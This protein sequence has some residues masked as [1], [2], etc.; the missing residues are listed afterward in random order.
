MLEEDLQMEDFPAYYNLDDSD[1]ED[2]EQGTCSTPK[3]QCG[4]K[5]KNP[6]N[7]AANPSPTKKLRGM[8]GRLK[9]ILEM[10][11]DILV[12]I[13]GH[14]DPLALI[15]LTWTTKGF[16]ILLLSKNADSRAIWKASI[17][18]VPG[19]PPCPGDLSEPKY[20]YLAFVN[21][22][23]R[24]HKWGRNSNSIRIFWY[25][26]VRLCHSPCAEEEFSIRFPPNEWAD[27]PTLEPLIPIAEFAARRYFSKRFHTATYNRWDE[28]YQKA[29]NKKAWVDN[30]VEV[31]KRLS[32]HAGACK[33]WLYEAER[34]ARNAREREAEARKP[35]VRDMLNNLGWS[36][37]ISML[38]QR[39]DSYG[40]HPLSHPA[41]RKACRKKITGL[42]L[43]RLERTLVEHMEK[44]KERRL[45]NVRARLLRERLPLLA[46]VY[47]TYV[48]DLPANFI[49]PA[50]ADIFFHPDV[51]GIMN[52]PSEMA[53]TSRDF[54]YL[55]F[56]FSTIVSHVL[57]YLETKLTSMISSLC[58]PYGESGTTSRDVL[59]LAVTTF[60]C[61]EHG[62]PYNAGL[63][64]PQM[65]LHRCANQGEYHQIATNILGHTKS[66]DSYDLETISQVCDST[67]WNATRC[68]KFDEDAYKVLTEALMM[69]ARDPKITTTE[70]MDSEMPI[71]ECLTCHSR[72]DGRLVMPWYYLANHRKEFHGASLSDSQESEGFEFCLLDDADAANAKARLLEQQQRG[73]SA[74]DFDDRMICMHC[75]QVGNAV[76][77]EDHVESCHDISP[78][79]EYD[80][81]PC[82]GYNNTSEKMT[83]IRLWP[84]RRDPPGPSVHKWWQLLL[85]GQ[86]DG[87]A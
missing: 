14:L 76:D 17:A 46:E 87:D 22:C 58:F 48:A 74:S 54:D 24:C 20:A 13:F 86:G 69:C 23:H 51:Q 18:N 55:R 5:R 72:H 37:E 6:A 47:K 59:S 39:K 1:G 9:D 45:R 81:V 82:I 70:D 2:D 83:S 53:V 75:K 7:K 85:V 71:F 50:L 78:I 30:K 64:Y 33:T 27:I 34:E 28:E 61:D 43:S 73:L 68:I 65:L 63:R 8:R 32:A 4:S 62:C 84:P 80:I 11:M 36:E 67:T 41:V 25:A 16:R 21:I 3:K 26:R 49:Y 44:I 52:L 66:D 12:E 40:L 29:E 57:Q 38:E 10:P 79:T 31:Q 77:L 60:V 19:L 56:S 35:I 15:H 42:V